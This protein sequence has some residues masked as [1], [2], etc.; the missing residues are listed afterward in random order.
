MVIFERPGAMPVE[1]M[2]RD[3]MMGPEARRFRI[4][5]MIVMR[6]QGYTDTEIGATFNLCRE[7]VNRLING[8][9]IHVKERLREVGLG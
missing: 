1:V 8:A 3:R 7:T 5:I 2:G 6:K 9:P 4:R